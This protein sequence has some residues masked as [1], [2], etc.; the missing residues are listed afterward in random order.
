[1]V[2]S[3]GEHVGVGEL[4]RATL[5]LL[6]DEEDGV[7]HFGTEPGDGSSSVVCQ[8]GA[9]HGHRGWTLSAAAQR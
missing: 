9:L 5:D 4:A 8:V 2:I 3:S 1:L 7:W 6:L